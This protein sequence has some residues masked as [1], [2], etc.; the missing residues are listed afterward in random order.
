MGERVALTE[1]VRR[2]PQR[3]SRTPWLES[4][5]A[6]QVRGFFG[7]AGELSPGADFR[8]M[9]A[10][11][12]K[13]GNAL[14]SGDFRGALEAGALTAAAMG[15]A[16]LPGSVGAA[17]NVLRAAP[18]AM[19]GG[20][21]LEGPAMAD[22]VAR[23][24]REGRASEVTDDMLARLDAEGE[25]RLFDLYEQGATGVD[26]PM[27]T[28]SRAARAEAMGVDNTEVYHGTRRAFHYF[29]NDAPRATDHGF[30]GRGTYFGRADMADEYAGKTKGSNIIP[31]N[32][33]GRIKQVEGTSWHYSDV[34]AEKFKSLIE[35]EG[36][37]G[38]DARLSTDPSILAMSGLGPEDAGALVERVVYDPRLIRSRFARFDPRLAHLRNLSAGVGGGVVAYNVLDD[39]G[40]ERTVFSPGYAE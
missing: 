19:R 28:A 34:E 22:E 1:Y 23:L 3:G 8:D 30:M 2:R 24:L 14:A 13:A 15:A 9:Y 25:A 38:V 5:D 12:G 4:A 21:A 10:Y 16:F 40:R 6:D 20:R 26:M 33:K 18:D 39:D 17:D 37:D 36:F 32:T 27:D 35:A 7:M 29:D 31:A 11:G